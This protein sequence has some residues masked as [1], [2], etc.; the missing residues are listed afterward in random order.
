MSSTVRLHILTCC[1]LVGIIPSAL[2]ADTSSIVS[3]VRTI[4]PQLS[5]VLRNAVLQSPVFRELVTRLTESDVIVYVKT[6][7]HL[8]T[9]LEGH[10]RFVGCGGGRR[11]V[12]VTVA[13]GRPEARAMATLGHELQHALEIAERPEIIDSATLARAFAEFGQQSTHGRNGLAF[14]TAAAIEAGQRIW[15]E[16]RQGVG[17]MADRQFERERRP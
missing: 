16:V 2:A 11:Y 15:S 9:G 8:P 12:V 10:L 3:H 13:W 1:F 4:E 5:G 14:E 6:G 17:R 7:R